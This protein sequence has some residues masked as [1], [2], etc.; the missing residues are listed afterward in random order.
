MQLTIEQLRGCL[1]AMAL[2]ADYTGRA[3]AFVEGFCSLNYPKP[4]A[5]TWIKNWDAATLRRLDPALGLVIVADAPADAPTDGYNLLRCAQPKAAFFGLLERFFGGE[6]ATGTGRTSVIETA[7]V[8]KNLSVGEHCYIGPDV[9]IGD[10]AVIGHNV[11]IRGRV[12][13]G[14]R[15]LIHSGVVIGTDGFGFYTDENGRHHKALQFGGVT[16]GDDVEIGANCCI[17]C[18]TI[19]DTRLGDNVKLDNL[20][21]VGHNVVLEDSVMLTAMTMLAGSAR[22]KKRVYTAPGVL[23]MNQITMGEDAYAG[24]GAV[25]TKDVPDNKVVVGVPARVL[26]DHV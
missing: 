10:D 2:E 24:L 7:R 19:D 25:I 1:A 16:I 14:D 17:D 23:V 13:I 6:P 4:R 22:L 12:R 5:L 21:H 9:T 8:G 26:R 18:G 11:T 3:D 20:C 15:A